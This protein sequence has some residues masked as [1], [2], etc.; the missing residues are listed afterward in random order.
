M[1]TEEF[2]KQYLAQQNHNQE[3]RAK[4]QVTKPAEVLQM[5]IGGIYSFRLLPQLMVEFDTVSFKSRIDGSF[6]N[7][8]LSPSSISL[9]KDA[10]KNDPI[11]EKMWKAWAAVKTS[12]DNA[13]KAEA[14]QLMPKTRKVAGIYLISD[15]LNADNDGQNKVLDFGAGFN[16][17]TKE[18]AGNI[19]KKVYAATEGDLASAY[20]PKLFDLG[21]NGVTIRIKVAKKMIGDKA[22]P[23]YSVD[24]LPGK[25]PG[26][27]EK[28]IKEIMANTFDLNKYVPLLRPMNEINQ[29]LATHWDCKEEQNDAV[30]APDAPEQT[31]TAWAEGD[32]LSFD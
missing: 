3:E 28:K 10:I 20:G 16:S 21:D 14:L 19:W 7:L 9:G 15:S 31:P 17:K 29:I 8:G 13:V 26:M 4:S 22:V 27:T 18:P 6:Q 5:K 12:T 2:Y 23:E 25:I 1:N 11:K 32:D 30:D 24:F